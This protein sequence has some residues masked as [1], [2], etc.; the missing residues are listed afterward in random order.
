MSGVVL[1]S[2]ATKDLL[3]NGESSTFLLVT[4][5]PFASLRVTRIP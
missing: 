1:R 5:R 4:S 3:V 2:E